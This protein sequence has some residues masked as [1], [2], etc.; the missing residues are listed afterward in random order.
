VK[1]I[2]PALSA[3]GPFLSDK[4]YNVVNSFS[5]MP[6]L[7]IPWPKVPKGSDKERKCCDIFRLVIVLGRMRGVQVYCLTTAARSLRFYILIKNQQ[8]TGRRNCRNGEKLWTDGTFESSSLIRHWHIFKIIEVICQP[9][10]R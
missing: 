2:C 7:G 5:F 3:K 6:P 9:L 10:L 4:H 8:P 1:R